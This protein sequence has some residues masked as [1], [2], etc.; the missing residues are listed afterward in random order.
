M[1]C[2]CRFQRQKYDAWFLYLL[3][4]LTPARHASLRGP[5]LNQT[6]KFVFKNIW[7]HTF[8]KNKKNMVTKDPV[9]QSTQQIQLNMFVL[10]LE[11]V[12]TVYSIRCFKEFGR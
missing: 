11:R 12:R 4:F 7:W 10:V 9:V 2:R 6:I 1:C 3:L 8:N 5:H